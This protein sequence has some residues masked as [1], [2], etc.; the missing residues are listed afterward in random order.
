MKRAHGGL[1]LGLS[2]VKH[3]I[4]PHEGSIVAEREAVGHVPLEAGALGPRHVVGLG[5][6]GEGQLGGGERDGE[7]GAAAQPF[8]PEQLVT[9]V[10]D[11]ASGGL[12]R[13]VTLALENRGPA[14]PPGAR[15]AAGA[16]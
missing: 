10:A 1:G 16:P 4:E 9:R 14:I 5:V 13:R 2:V 6:G 7:R 3:L 12:R 8:V 11:L 15:L